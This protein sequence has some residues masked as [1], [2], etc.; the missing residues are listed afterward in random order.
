MCDIIQAAE[1]KSSWMILILFGNATWPPQFNLWSE[2]R[3]FPSFVNQR[4]QFIPPT[5]IQISILVTTTHWTKS[6]RFSGFTFQTNA[7]S[8]IFYL[9]QHLQSCSG[10]SAVF[11]LSSG[12]SVGG[13]G[14]LHDL[15]HVTLVLEVTAAAARGRDRLSR[16]WVA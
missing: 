12:G 13:G 11:R 7:E 9:Q 10:I 15:G 3:R 4:R 5:S 8:P 2:S 14:A 16:W 6:L 1:V